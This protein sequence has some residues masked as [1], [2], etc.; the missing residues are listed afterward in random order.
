M[1]AST[2]QAMGLDGTEISQTV[3]GEQPGSAADVLARTDEPLRSLIESM[4]EELK[5][6][7]EMLALLDRQ[8]DFA[9]TTTNDQLHDSLT[10]VDAQG[11]A[12]QSARNHRELCRRGLAREWQLPE[13]TP[14]VELAL[15]LP[16]DYRPLVK[17]LLE[18]NNSLSLRVQQQVCQN[19]VLLSH[20]Q[21]PSPRFVASRIPSGRATPCGSTLPFAPS[22]PSRVN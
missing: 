3:A 4:R 11:A 12:I 1:N 6:Y 5:Q 22:Y 14:L 17:A 20:I 15:L 16:P 21:D 13:N 9:A 8:H 2:Y 10:A 18:E 19:H 7:G